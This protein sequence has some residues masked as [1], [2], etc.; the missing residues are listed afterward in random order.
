MHELTP[1]EIVE[2]CGLDV[3]TNTLIKRFE[4]LLP[5]LVRELLKEEA[6]ASRKRT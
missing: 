5:R 2:V 3:K 6:F 4:R 1:A